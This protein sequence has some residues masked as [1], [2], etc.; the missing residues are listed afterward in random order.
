MISE[1]LIPDHSCRYASIFNKLSFDEA[2]SIIT[3]LYGKWSF[4]IKGRITNSLAFELDG[5]EFD[6]E[7][8]RIFFDYYSVLFT[9]AGSIAILYVL[10]KKQEPDFTMPT[11]IQEQLF[12]YFEKL[13]ESQEFPTRF[14][15]PD[16]F[17]QTME[18]FKVL[19]Q[20]KQI[21]ESFFEFGNKRSKWLDELEL[22]RPFSFRLNY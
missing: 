14:G 1:L 3:E 9:L 5:T 16:H 8:H 10:K 18:A 13:M 12:T 4:S 11:D 6:K 21:N 7:E 2:S 20:V 22:D 15:T 19:F 17:K